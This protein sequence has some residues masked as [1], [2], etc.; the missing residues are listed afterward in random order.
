VEL[1]L[2][3]CYYLQINTYTHTLITGDIYVYEN[4]N[5]FCAFND[6]A[7]WAQLSINSSGQATFGGNTTI[8]GL[9]AIGT[10]ASNTY[11]LRVEY[12][13]GLTS[14]A[15]I[16]AN[17]TNAAGGIH[18]YGI[19]GCATGTGYT[20]YGIYGYA[21]G[22]AINWAGYFAGNVYA[23]GTYQSSDKRLKKNITP[24]N[25]KDLLSKI[26]LLKPVKFQFLSEEELKLKGLPALNTKEGDHIGLLAQDVEKIFPEFVID[27]PY[28]IEDEKESVG[29]DT[30]VVTKAINYQELSIALL[31]AVQELKA[32]VE[33]LKAE[34]NNK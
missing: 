8:N 30:K 26:G 9:T 15:A 25:G 31:A 21:T 12:N 7:I 1:K 17:S 27:V 23:T 18:S 5:S 20:N 16:Y 13:S 6:A 11:K 3:Y 24:L 2:E 34:L 10:S 33:E 32:Q 4:L 22:A 28:V 14:H 19:Q 29:D